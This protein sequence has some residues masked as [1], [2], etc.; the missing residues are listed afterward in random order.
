MSILDE[1]RLLARIATLYYVDNLKQKEISERL[2]ISQSFV[3]RA[4]TKCI[5]EGIVQ[6][7][8][9]PP[10]NIFLQLE[11]ELQTK[12]GISNA[13]VVDADSDD[14]EKI[15]N[16]I[17]SAAAYYLQV[18]LQPNELVGVSAWSS[19]IKSMVDNM[20]PLSVKAQGVVQ[21]LGGVGLNRNVQ[22]NF[23][24]YELAKKLNCPSYLLPS[25]NA[26]SAVGDISYKQQQLA[27]SEV[28]DVIDMFPKV[29][30]A[31]VGIGTLE[32]SSLLRWSGLHYNSDILQLL[33]KKGAVGDICLH[34]YDQHGI[35]V[36]AE[37]EDPMIGMNLELIQKCQRV[38][39]LA[40]GRSKVSAIKGA[41]RG[42]YIDVLITDYKTAQTL[43]ED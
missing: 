37:N 33:A 17:G 27:I 36:L 15:K 8:V 4:L 10:A 21:L 7:N 24:T 26:V 30:V 23:L 38:I 31:L 32:P 41:L 1:K 39:A 43:L 42:H 16:T 20:P 13:I 19:T 34:Y 14:D 22:A 18:T 40:G 11:Q 6:I 25:Q 5:T 2:N 9:I 3:S 35:P 28:S 12:F 29:D